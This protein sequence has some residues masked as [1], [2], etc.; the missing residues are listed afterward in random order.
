VSRLSELIEEHSRWREGGVNLIA[1][2]NALGPEA[3]RVLGSDLQGRYHSPWYGGTKIIDEIVGE[4]ER[5]ARRLFG[6][7]HAIVT[8]L[9]GNLCDLAVIL[10]LT[11]PGDGVAMVPASCGGYPLNVSLFGRR[12][13]DLPMVP[14]GYDP[15][16]ERMGD[17]AGEAALVIGGSSFIP[18]PHPVKALGRTGAPVVY[19]GSHVLGLMACGGFQSPLSEGA[20]VLIGSTHKS[21]PGPQGG[22][23]LTDDDGMHRRLGAVLDFGIEGDI[24]LVDNPHP[25]RIAALGLALLELEEDADYASRVVANARALAAGLV[26]AGVPV[27]FQDRGYTASHQIFLDLDLE[28]GKVY[29]AALEKEGIFIDIAGRLGTAEV[30]RRG[31]SPDDMAAVADRMAA[32]W[33]GLFGG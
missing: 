33:R 21:L 14:G 17:L 28:R 11:A 18:F 3:R 22:V 31:M 32:V 27:R 13:V 7:R 25:A 4:T 8:P 24:G 20:A 15:D 1:S 30:T 12:R 29:C 10:A 19:D 5:I 6:C 9:S 26:S 16:P 23:V 2:E